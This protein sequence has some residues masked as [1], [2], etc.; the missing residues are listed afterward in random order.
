MKKSKLFISLLLSVVIAV[1]SVGCS[2]LQ[3][4]TEDEDE[5]RVVIT[6]SDV[7]ELAEKIGTGLLRRDLTGFEDISVDFDPDSV[8]ME[9]PEGS[10]DY[11][12][13]RSLWYDTFAYEIDSIYIGN[14]YA[15]AHL[16]FSFADTRIGGT[17]GLLKEEWI[18]TLKEPEE[19]ASTTLMLEMEYDDELLVTNMNEVVEDYL[20][21]EDGITIRKI[22]YEDI[23]SFEITGGY[24]N[25]NAV[26]TL[27][28]GDEPSVD[29]EEIAVE[30]VAP[31]GNAIYNTTVYFASNGEE[32]M[33]LSPAEYGNS[34][35]LFEE[36]F[37]TVNAEINGV[38]I[39]GSFKP[40][41]PKPEPVLSDST[42][43]LAYAKEEGFKTCSDEVF[44]TVQDGVYTNG[45]FGIEIPYADKYIPLTDQK[46]SNNVD[47][48]LVLYE[49][50][51]NLALI[52]IYK[53]DDAEAKAE[54]YYGDSKI[55]ANGVTM[56]TEFYVDDSS[57]TTLYCIVKEDNVFILSMLSGSVIQDEILAGIKAI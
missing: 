20:G 8:N 9:E 10:D 23:I 43:F 46:L 39:S 42:S 28:F 19:I 16:V 7:T 47:L 13:L 35:G 17:K 37:Y 44:G 3:K 2:F 25:K 11:A 26:I 31:S 5:E 51:Y 45:Y 49:N 40:N 4:R 30:V 27:K 38:T 41:A 29:G 57:D 54:K 55:E 18:E 56:Y 32:T 36:D 1:S 12:D 52:L 21:I 33:T 22:D 6:D 34:N 48:E 53:L 50:D 15:T 24:S 14:G